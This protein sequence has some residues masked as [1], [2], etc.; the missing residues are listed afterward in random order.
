MKHALFC[1]TVGKLVM[2]EHVMM[3]KKTMGAY[4]LIQ[5]YCELITAHIPELVDVRKHLMA[6]YGK[7]FV[8]EAVELRPD[9]GLVQK[10]STRAPDGPTKI[11]ILIEIAEE[12]NVK[13][14][15]SL[16]ENDEKLSHHLLVGLKDD[17][18]SKASESSC[19]GLGVKSSRV[20]Y[21]SKDQKVSFKDNWGSSSEHGSAEHAAS[22]PGSEPRNEETVT[23][24]ARVQ[25]SSSLTKAM[26]PDKEETSKPLSC[27]EDIP[28]KEKAQHVLACL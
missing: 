27:N 2:V 7:E 10:L 24:S 3:E 1:C 4:H 16:E 20:S 8:S 25:P 19:S 17:P 22:K 5:I 6:R 18:L 11:R 23:L 14:Q 12:Y 21:E 15:P 13:W 28:S 9:C 26:I